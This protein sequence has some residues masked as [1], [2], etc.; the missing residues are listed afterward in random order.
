MLHSDFRLG[1]EKFK[2]HYSE[3][4]ANTEERCSWLSQARALELMQSARMSSLEESCM[5]SHLMQSMTLMLLD[6]QAKS[7]SLQ[8]HQRCKYEQFRNDDMCDVTSD[9]ILL[10]QIE[11]R[12]MS[13]DGIVYE[14]A[15]HHVCR[16]ESHHVS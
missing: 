3:A 12:G 8:F 16:A 9:D 1:Y 11:R 13:E 10:S 4:S 14:N 2:F 6:I 5:S 7:N 15:A